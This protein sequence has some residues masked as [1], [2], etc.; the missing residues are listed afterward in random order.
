MARKHQ[1][2]KTLLK[3]SLDIADLF[4]TLKY[5]YNFDKNHPDYC[6]LE[7][8]LIFC[9]GQGSGKSLSIAQYVQEAV[10]AYPEA[11]LCTNMKFVGLPET[12]KVVP[13][14]GVDSL[15]SLSNG[16]KGVLYVIDEIHLEFNSLE[17]KGIDI[18]VIEEICQQRKQR[19]HI[20]GSSQVYGR[21]A[22]PFRE[23]I[24]YVVLCSNIFGLI[25]YNRLIDGRKTTEKDGKLHTQTTKNYIWFHSPRLYESYDTYEKMKRYREE[26]KGGKK[27]G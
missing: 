18:K 13:Y 15:F 22:K 11:I 16:E 24:R 20:I 1:T 5:K 23:Q 26:W 21:I 2:T 17:S 12:V 9:G 19:K 7:G 27:C 14:E 4:S 25:Q 8:L 10:K 3:G 6:Y